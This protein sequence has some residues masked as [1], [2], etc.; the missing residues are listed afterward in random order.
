MA[1]TQVSYHLFDNLS[2]SSY[3]L[4]KL[5][6]VGG[7]LGCGIASS[8]MQT[9]YPIDTS[10]INVVSWPVNTVRVIKT[11]TKKAIIQWR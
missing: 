8:V 11:K 5:C 3:P 4:R 7:G 2:I 6:E 10:S 1:P 9:K